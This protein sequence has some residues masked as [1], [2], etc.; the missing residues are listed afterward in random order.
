MVVLEE[1]GQEQATTIEG[2]FTFVD[3]TPG[4]YHLRV[5]ADGMSPQRL[6]I[7]ARAGIAPFNIVLDPDVPFGLPFRPTPFTATF[8][9]RVANVEFPVTVPVEGRSQ[10]NIF[11]GEKRAELHV[12]PRFAVTA[13]PATLVVP[14]RATSANARG[15]TRDV[16]VTVV[17]HARGASKGEVSLELPQGWSATPA[18]SG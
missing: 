7:S 11:S 17:N 2:R 18:S 12:V 5:T 13:G 9:L 4:T 16:R 10:G 6:E 8:T 3:V 15:T 1:T 14:T